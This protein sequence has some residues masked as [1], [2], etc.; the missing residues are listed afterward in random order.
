[1]GRQNVSAMPPLQLE[2][3]SNHSATLTVTQ[4][5]QKTRHIQYETLFAC[6]LLLLLSSLASS[7]RRATCS[8]ALRG[9]PS[10]Q[11]LRQIRSRVGVVSRY[12]LL[13][14]QIALTL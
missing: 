9:L 10:P 5:R 14:S 12:A 13:A 11:P 3:C 8:V 2:K 6:T 1:M 4:I 7:F